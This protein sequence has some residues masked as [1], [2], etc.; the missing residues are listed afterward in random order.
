MHLIKYTGKKKTDSVQLSNNA[1][2]CHIQDPANYTAYELI[3]MLKTC[4][5]YSLQLDECTDILEPAVL[6]VFF[7]Y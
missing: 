4:H 2:A 3:R 1:V 6:L 5:V 7:Q